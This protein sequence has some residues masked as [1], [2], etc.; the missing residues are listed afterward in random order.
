MIERLNVGRRRAREEWEKRQALNARG[1]DGGVN[2]RSPGDTK[3]NL[4][5]SYLTGHAVPRVVF[6]G[7]PRQLARKGNAFPRR[8]L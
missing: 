7:K 5:I 8:S 2:R 4:H 6:W 1:A 3:S